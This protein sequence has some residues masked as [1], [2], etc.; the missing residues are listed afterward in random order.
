MSGW[1]GDGYCDVGK[2]FKKNNHQVTRSV[3]EYE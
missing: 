2:D 3:R 1:V